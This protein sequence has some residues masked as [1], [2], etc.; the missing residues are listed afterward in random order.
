[1]HQIIVPKIFLIDAPLNTGH[2]I[3]L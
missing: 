3:E 2:S 1:L